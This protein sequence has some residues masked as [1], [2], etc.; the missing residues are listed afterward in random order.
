MCFPSHLAAKSN[1]RSFLVLSWTKSPG[2]A[3]QNCH[4]YTQTR[5]IEA[6]NLED[7][8][9][10]KSCA[11]F[12]M[13]LRTYLSNLS[14]WNT[15]CRHPLQSQFPETI[16]MVFRRRNALACWESIGRFGWGKGAVKQLSPNHGKHPTDCTQEARL[17]KQ[18]IVECDPS[19]FC[20]KYLLSQS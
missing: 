4:W 8:R 19:W 16:Q 17:N 2:W 18:V 14:K 3:S 9:G 6:S 12:D 20:L 13:L 1:P 15:W 5:Y 10:P 7:S 11:K